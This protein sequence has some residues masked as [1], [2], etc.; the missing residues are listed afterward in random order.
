MSLSIMEIS[1]ELQRSTIGHGMP[2]T[3][4]QWLR[5]LGPGII[6]MLADTDAGSVVTAAQSGAQFGASLLIPDLLLI[7][8]LYLVQEMTVRLG[9]VTG[10]GH[11]ELIEKY[12][13][14][15]WATLSVLTLFL[16]AVGALVTEYA[17]IATVGQ[18]LGASKFWFV[19]LVALALMSAAFLGKYRRAERFGIIL[20]LL[21]LAFI[22]AAFFG[23]F[24][25]IGNVKSI[26]ILPFGHED[27]AWM[28]AANVGAVVMPWMIFFQ[29]QAVSD[30]GLTP[31]QLKIARRDT[32][33]GAV[34]TQAVMIAVMFTAAEAFPHHHTLT[35]I[36]SLAQTLVPLL[37]HSA[38]IIFGAGLFGASTVAAL[39][40][41]LAG[42]WGM[43]EVFGWKHSLN[44]DFKETP[45]FHIVYALSH[46]IAVIF[47]LV[48]IQ[49]VSLSIDVEIMN[50]ML[51]PI[52]LG[53]LIA[54]EYRALPHHWKMSHRRRVLVIITSIVTILLGLLTL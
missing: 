32:L 10:Q 18:L 50:A 37:G 1:M 44:S 11:G 54:L 26:W 12:F 38:I 8:V 41:S 23:L 34:L 53:F 3:T 4:W 29:Q 20:G 33:L 47:V 35:S 46:V 17:G 36:A 42:A 31:G 5:L 52:V 43:A 45:Q 30:S 2:K 13:G 19:P 22:P 6:V 48:A 21:E 49:F 9:L 40:V 28:V 25:G 24:K 16:S 27:F 15:K 39:V 14:R 51:L 7:G